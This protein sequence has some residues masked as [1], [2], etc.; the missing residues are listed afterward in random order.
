M[1]Q[2]SGKTVALHLGAGKH[3]GL[4]DGGVTQPMVQHLALVLS[5]VGPV[6]HLLDIAVLLMWSINLQLLDR[7]AVV[8]HHAHAQLLDARRECGAEHHGLLAL[9]GQ[10]VDFGQIVR[11]AQVE[12]AVG[13]VHHQELHLVELDLHRALQVQ[14]AAWGG[15]HQIGV[16]QLGNLQLVRHAAHHVGNAQATGMFD[17]VDGIVCHLLGQLTGWADDQRAGHSRLEVAVVG[18][19][20]ALGALWRRFTIGC[21]LGH[22]T[23]VFRTRFS[24]S[25]CMLADQRV[26]HRQQERGG[27]AA[28]GLAGN[29]QIDETTVFGACTHGQGNGLELNG[30]GLG[31]AK[32]GHSLHQ[33]RRQAQLDEAVGQLGGFYCGVFGNLLDCVC[34]QNVNVLHRNV[35]G[36][37][38]S[39]REFAL[40]LKSVGHIFLT[41]A[42]PLALPAVVPSMV[43]KH[44][45]SNGT[46]TGV[47]G[48]A[49]YL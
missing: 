43:K 11:E 20:F 35:G 22:R 32:I 29:H 13:L 14:Q 24:F 48:A 46:C 47:A 21:S 42:R 17:Q 2:I 7:C 8:V 15:H 26:Q 25:F 3:D 23:L 1:L 41:R 39:R 16:L 9:N 10:L 44:Q 18:R 38:F 28:A 31:V 6:Q 27:L 33:L 34:I 30:G 12:H 19:V 49:G 36:K 5:V 40:H 45:P 4:V 37:R